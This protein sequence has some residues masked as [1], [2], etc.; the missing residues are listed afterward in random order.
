LI[1]LRNRIPARVVTVERGRLLT[2]IAL[3]AGGHVIE[4][5]ITTRSSHLLELA[6]GDTVEALV[7]ANEMSVMP[8][9]RS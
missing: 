2:R 7:K 9:P 8:E 6:A 1:S 3:D 4:S 5:V